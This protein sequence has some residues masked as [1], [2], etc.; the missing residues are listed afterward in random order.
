LQWTNGTQN[1]SSYV[2]L[3]VTIASNPFGDTSPRQGAAG[4]VNVQGLP[5][6]LKTVIGGV[7]QR[8]AYGPRMELCAWAFPFANG[9]TMTM[10]LVNDDGTVT[11][12]VAAAAIFSIGELIVGRLTDLPTLV[13]N[14]PSRAPQ[15]PTA[16]QRSAGGQLWQL[17]RKPWWQVSAVLGRFSASDVKGGSASSIASGGNPA[18]KI[19]IQTL[20]MLLSTT[21]VCAIC[22]TAHNGKT[23]STSNGINYD[24][25]FMQGSWLLARPS[26]IGAATLDDPPLWSWN[27]QLMEAT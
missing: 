19:D 27:I 21:P 14:S 6:N 15:D 9:T 18:G 1:T 7:T 10:R 23:Y 13:Y 24:A 26:A 25:T 11:P 5:L 12:P 2:E 17:M 8:L 3:T 4:F 16:F 20:A 22:D